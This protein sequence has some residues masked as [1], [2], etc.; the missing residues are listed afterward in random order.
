MNPNEFIDVY[1]S[2]L[3]QKISK[4]EKI[5]TLMGEFNIDLPKYNTNAD[6]TAFL[7]SMYTSF[8]LPDITNPTRL[9]HTQK[10][11]LIRYF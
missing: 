1:M 10:H 3:Y 6:S 2:D 8:F 9:Q 5:M 4:E 11:S 7:D